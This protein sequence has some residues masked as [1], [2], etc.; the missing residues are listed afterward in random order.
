MISKS[1]VGGD[2]LG[3]AKYL[4]KEGLSEVLYAQGVRTENA[5]MM[6]H[7]FEAHRVANTRSKAKPVWHSSLSFSPRDSIT[8]EIMIAAGQLF[9]EQLGL[10]NT[11][12]AIIAHY[13]KEHYAHCHLIASRIDFNSNLIS[14]KHTALRGKSACREIEKELGLE[15]FKLTYRPNSKISQELRQEQ[16]EVSAIVFLK[17]DEHRPE[18]V[19]SNI[20]LLDAPFINNDDDLPYKPYKKKKK[21]KNVDL[22]RLI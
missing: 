15:S 6:A 17:S 8:K 18:I 10:S 2:F 16:S 4:L 22:N 13:D 1:I 11:Q 20:S 14:D 3:L 21:G 9:A 7:D 5:L 19:P 12:Y